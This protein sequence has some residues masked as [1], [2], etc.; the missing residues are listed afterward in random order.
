MF[1][2][3]HA[4]RAGLAVGVENT[5]VVASVCQRLQPREDAAIAWAVTRAML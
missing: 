4:I 1:C 5:F 3:G 2:V